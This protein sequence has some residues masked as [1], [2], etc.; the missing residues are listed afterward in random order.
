MRTRPLGLPAAAFLLLVSSSCVTARTDHLPGPPKRAVIVDTD[1]GTDDL[2]AITMLLARGDVRVVGITV[3]NGLAHVPAGAEN[4]LRLL[5]LAGHFEIPV[6]AGRST[7]LAGTAAFPDEWRQ[8]CDK[9]P[10]VTLPAA[11]RMVESRSAAE[12]LAERLSDRAAPVDLL[13]LGPLTNIAEA[14]ARRPEAAR[15]VRSIVIMGGA[16]DV[17]GNIREGFPDASNAAEFNIFVDPEAAREV[18]AS[19]AA[20]LLVPLDATNGV[21]IDARFVDDVRANAGTPAGRFVVEVLGTIRD[22]I[23]TGTYYAWDL[24]ATALFLDPTIAQSREGRLLVATTGG[25][26]GRTTLD[27]GSPA[28]HVA[29]AIDAAAFRRILVRSVQASAPQKER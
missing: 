28:A 21:P 19:G 11:R 6:Y 27:R 14:F 22:W 5:T 2:M 15:T 8:V 1:A 16:V 23:S 18:F 20:L 10:G 12:F 13:V 4:V 25:D 17:P 3:A 24:V 29:T 26:A 9:L 7:P